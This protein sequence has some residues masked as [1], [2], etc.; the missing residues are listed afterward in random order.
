ME[1]TN[2]PKNTPEKKFRVGAICA[3]VWRN[4]TIKDGVE[5][6]FKTIS[7]ERSYKDKEGNWKNTSSLRQTDLPK[8]QLV[9]Y[10]AYKYLSLAD[11]AA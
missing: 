3:T 4:T 9:L 7:F 10:E 11:S 6:E 1:Q 5:N 2:I 8:A